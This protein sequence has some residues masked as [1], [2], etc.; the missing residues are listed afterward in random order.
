MPPPT[1][2]YRFQWRAEFSNQS[3]NALHAEAFNHAVLD[4]D[5]LTQV[6]THSLGWVCAFDQG[7]LI[8][9]VNVPWDGDLHASIL[10]TA[11]LKRYERQGVG[12]R[13]VAL[14]A[15]Q[16]R[17]AGLSVAARRLRRGGAAPLLLRC[18]RLRP[19]H[20]RPDRPD[21]T[22]A[23]RRHNGVIVT[24]RPGSARSWS[25]AGTRKDRAGGDRPTATPVTKPS[26]KNL[27]KVGNAL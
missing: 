5:W 6:R 16:A 13:L 21:G 20:R 10:D 24:C 22:S 25:G 26:R 1:Q 4:D 14:A 12:R 9:F 17:A 11:V 15:E 3:L 18:L 2:P 23:K 8:G 19:N 7:T 27:S